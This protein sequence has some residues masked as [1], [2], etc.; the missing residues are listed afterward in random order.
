M[1]IPKSSIVLRLDPQLL[2]NPDADIRYMLPDLL[3]ERSGG[4]ICDNG[5]DYVGKQNFLMLFLL[6]TA[7][8]S[9]LTC[10]TDVLDNERVLGNDLLK[11]VTVALE[12]GSDY[13][14]FFPAK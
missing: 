9:A 6:A 8:Q 1:N 10:I 13:E 12:R 5:Y 7:V 3:A 14:V 11:S 2:D 4:Q